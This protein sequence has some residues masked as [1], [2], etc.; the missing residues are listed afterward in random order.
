[1]HILSKGDG[2][3]V[4]VRILR[5]GRDGRQCSARAKAG[6]R[7]MMESDLA[8]MSSKLVTPS[9]FSTLE[10]ILMYWPRGPSTC[11]D[12]GAGEYSLASYAAGYSY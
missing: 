7:T 3:G 10:M 2:N 12:E 11:G 5:D 1:M 8:R 6:V 9:W 4:R